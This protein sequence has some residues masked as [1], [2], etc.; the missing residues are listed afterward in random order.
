MGSD[1]WVNLPVVIELKVAKHMDH[2]EEMA[3]EAI[4]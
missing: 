3:E 1:P 4:K 2:L